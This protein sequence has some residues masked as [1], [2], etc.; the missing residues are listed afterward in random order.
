M[1]PRV[2]SLPTTH[3]HFGKHRRPRPGCPRHW[4]RPRPSQVQPHQ[5]PL[6]GGTASGPPAWS[7]VRGAV[8]GPAPPS[9]G[10]GGRGLR[11]PVQALPG[12]G[13]SL[14]S[15]QPG[16]GVGS[17]GGERGLRSPGPAPEQGVRPEMPCQALPGR[18]RS[19]RSPIKFHR[20]WSAA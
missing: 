8:S 3:M 17:E 14:R 2:M 11:S 13:Q 18:G 10:P 1:E 6:G 9:A 19:P 7:Q 5:A 4:V 16:T 20:V 15:L 12:R